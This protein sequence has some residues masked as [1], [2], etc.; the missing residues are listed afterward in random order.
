M[1]ATKDTPAVAKY[2]AIE[3]KYLEARDRNADDDAPEVLELEDLA[4]KAWFEL[5]DEEMAFVNSLPP[6]G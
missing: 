1:P 3:A 6:R 5:S 2:L 4:E